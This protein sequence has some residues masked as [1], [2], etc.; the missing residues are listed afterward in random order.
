MRSSTFVDVAVRP[1]GRTATSF[2]LYWTA[3]SEASS[4]M[5]MGKLK[6]SVNAASV[7]FV[8]LAGFQTVESVKLSSRS[9]SVIVLMTCRF[10]G[11]GS[12]TGILGRN[13]NEKDV[14]SR[15]ARIISRKSLD[16]SFEPAR[17]IR[18]VRCISVYSQV[19]RDTMN[20]CDQSQHR[21]PKPEQRETHN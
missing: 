12:R 6:G 20:V 7:V 21:S 1:I 15:R 2:P 9:S 11:A 4:V 5:S 18:A 10:C 16:T 19:A 3:I 14:S 8:A 17:T 13:Q